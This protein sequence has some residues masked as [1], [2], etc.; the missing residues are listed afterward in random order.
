MCSTGLGVDSWPLTD[1]LARGRGLLYPSGI[2]SWL[3]G[4]LADTQG[5]PKAWR[6]QILFTRMEEV[7]SRR[8]AVGAGHG[9]GGAAPGG[10]ASS[11]LVCFVPVVA[12]VPLVVES[13]RKKWYSVPAWGCSRLVLN[14]G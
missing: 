6:K 9:R 7:I 13:S 3:Y 1:L 5:I 12:L 11:L 4:H 2:R 14:R 8:V 10:C